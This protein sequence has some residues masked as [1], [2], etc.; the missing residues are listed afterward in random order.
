MAVS[1]TTIIAGAFVVIGVPIAVILLNR[2]KRS[3]GWW[4][5]VAFI[6]LLTAGNI[7]EKLITGTSAIF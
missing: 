6:A 3:A 7:A 2:W 4:L 5:L 1:W